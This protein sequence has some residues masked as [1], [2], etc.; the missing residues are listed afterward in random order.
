MAE[1]SKVKK[2]GFFARIGKWFRELKGECRKIV[3]PTR[4]QTTNNTLVVFACVIVVGIFIWVLD[5]VFGF[6]IQ[7]LLTSFAA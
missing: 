5:I 1:E 3:W 4:Q 2:P 7:A 6:G